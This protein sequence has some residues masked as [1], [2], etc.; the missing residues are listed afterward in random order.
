MQSGDATIA[1][2][3][4]RLLPFIM[5]LFFFSLLDRTNISFA[6]LEM[7]RDLGLTPK[8]YG[9]AAGVFFLG[10]CLF[11]IPSNLI[12]QR[13][14]ARIWLM[15]IMVT[16]GIIVAAMAWISGERSLYFMRFLLGVT[17]AGLFPGLLLYCKLWIPQRKIGTATSIL[18]ATTAIA[19]VLGGPISTLMMQT[20]GLA[21]FA[22]WQIMFLLQGLL[23]IVVGFTILLYL[24]SRIDD[25][26]WLDAGEKAWLQR[27]LAD[28][29]RAREGQGVT[30]FLQG[31]FGPRVLLTTAV[32]FTL[33]FCFFGTI[34]WLPQIIK[35][36][37][38]LSNM[39][40]GL[41]TSVPYLVGGVVG[42]LWGRRS[43]HRR[44][45]KLH[46][47]FG[48]VIA[49]LGYVAAGASVMQGLPTIYQFVGLCIAAIGVSMMLGLFWAFASDL[50]GGAAA[51]GGFAF[52]NSI[53]TLG[54][55]FGPFMI[56]YIQQLT[57]SF[58]GSLYGLAAVALLTGLL[59]L[60][61]RNV[62]ATGDATTSLKPAVKAA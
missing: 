35:A 36:F 12:L 39:Q 57:G 54:G 25:A 13:V 60:S 1:K 27:T 22:G 42:I 24:P 9:F 41:L 17:E 51:A 21:G 7:N 44:E 59:A 53:G 55:F 4:W 33:A 50:L 15:R 46:L 18:M 19:N 45:R 14:G 37:G 48:A 23:T 26:T 61:L 11:E 32:C 58:A 56:G 20:N 38:G 2:V 47:A 16:W 6:A 31:F 10:Y 40:V 28:E 8:V 34:F 30:G 29:D 49:A 3:M 5:L 52:I 62:V 43:D